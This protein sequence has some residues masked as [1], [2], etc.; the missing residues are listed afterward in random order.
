MK[1]L[2]GHKIFSREIGGSQKN[3]EIFRWLQILMTSLFNE[4]DQIGIRRLDLMVIGPTGY[5][6]NGFN[7]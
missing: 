2:G 5:R 1:K 4:L 7:V 6:L 3:Q